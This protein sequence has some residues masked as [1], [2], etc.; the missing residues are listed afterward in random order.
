[1]GFKLSTAAKELSKEIDSIAKKL[2]IAG[3]RALNKTA[4]QS[5]NLASKNIRQVLNL[6]ASRIKRI[7]KITRAS[8]NKMVSSVRAGYQPIPLIY[9]NGVRQVKKGVSVTMRKDKSRKVFK[10]AFMAT[11][12]SGH[13]GVF[14]RKSKARLPIKELKGPNPQKVFAENIGIITQQSGDILERVYNNELK[15][16]FSK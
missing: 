14:R 5:R 9:Y 15:F 4:T 6:K 8:K 11:M 3:V 13:K 2:E 10:G 12:P 7:L 1:M 16:I